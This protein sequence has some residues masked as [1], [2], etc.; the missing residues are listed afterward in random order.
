M[1]CGVCVRQTTSKQAESIGRRDSSEG[2]SLCSHHVSP[3]TEEE[4]SYPGTQERQR[5]DVKRVFGVHQSKSRIN[6]LPSRLW[7]RGKMKTITLCCRIVYDMVVEKRRT[8]EKDL[9]YD[10][11]IQVGKDCE[12]CYSRSTAYNSVQPGSIASICTLDIMSLTPVNTLI[13]GGWSMDT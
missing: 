7:R 5:K 10:G 8:L 1:P 9:L 6:A 12:S 2:S 11:Q 13:R 3:R 4:S